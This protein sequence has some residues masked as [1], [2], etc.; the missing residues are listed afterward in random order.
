MVTGAEVLVAVVT[1]GVGEDVLGRVCDPLNLDDKLSGRAIISSSSEG[2]IGK[3]CS[4]MSHASGC[5]GTWF[6]VGRT[7]CLRWADCSSSA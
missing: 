5:S 2:N 7:P 4:F 1:N 6:H 3:T